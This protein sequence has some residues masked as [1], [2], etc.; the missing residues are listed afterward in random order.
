MNHFLKTLQTKRAATGHNRDTVQKNNNR[1]RTTHN[2]ATIPKG[3]RQ[4]SNDDI[5]K[6][7]VSLSRAKQLEIE[8]M[9][10]LEKRYE[11]EMEESERDKY[12]GYE[13]NYAN[14]LCD[15]QDG[16]GWIRDLTL[17]GVEPN[18]GWTAQEEEEFE[19][20]YER[21]ERE[22]ELDAGAQEYEDE[23]EQYLLDV[24]DRGGWERD[25]TE[26]G[27]EPNPGH[28][29]ENTG[30]METCNN[31]P[32]LVRDHVHKYTPLSGRQRRVAENAKKEDGEKKGKR[33]TPKYK[34]CRGDPNRCDRDHGH[35]EHQN[36]V[37]PLLAGLY[38]GD[39]WGHH[40]LGPQK[41]ETEF[42]VA[43][44]E[45]YLE[46]FKDLMPSRS[47]ESDNED[48]MPGLEEPEP[49][50]A[51]A[52]AEKEVAQ[53]ERDEEETICDDISTA[54]P[55][56][57]E[58][59]KVNND[60]EVKRLAAVAGERKRR[61]E[62]ER[63]H[64]EDR[65]A[66]EDD[67]KEVKRLAAVAGERKRRVECERRH[68]EDRRAREEGREVEEE[69]D[70]YTDDSDDE[71]EE[72]EKTTEGTVAVQEEDER[73][74]EELEEPV[75]DDVSTA[76]S[77]EEDSRT[78]E[79]KSTE[80]EEEDERPR[81]NIPRWP[82]VERDDEGS[83]EDVPVPPGWV[84]MEVGVE[85]KPELTAP[86]CVQVNNLGY[87]KGA[88]DVP[89][90]PL[91]SQ[92]HQG[93]PVDG[94]EHGHRHRCSRCNRIYYHVHIGRRKVTEYF[95]YNALHPASARCDVCNGK[96]KVRKNDHVTA[97]PQ[98]VPMP[99]LVP[100]FKQKLIFVAGE[101]GRNRGFLYN[102]LKAFSVKKK[103]ITRSYDGLHTTTWDGPV[104]KE[105]IEVLGLFTIGSTNEVIRDYLLKIG[106]NRQYMGTIATWM[107]ELGAT[108]PDLIAISM[109]TGKGGNVSAPGRIR[110]SFANND[111][112]KK[113]MIS[114]P[115]VYLDT[116]MA[117]CNLHLLYQLRLST[118][119]PRAPEVKLDF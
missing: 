9:M 30:G 35:Q 74:E 90:A 107:F 42:R 34:E 78:G 49:A 50:V 80:E 58:T 17:E 41:E 16:E 117:L 6:R 20:E 103:A 59:Q 100:G 62:C 65:R 32:C 84:K 7:G 52:P 3:M 46:A 60:K 77:T 55:Q 36:K 119:L 76:P 79:T 63:R 23:Y 104:E 98:L 115:E 111:K 108:K 113:L 64:G 5:R 26:E 37:C 48:E 13:N 110:G 66:R 89:L 10:R 38:S 61:V 29:H 24:M 40:L 43:E 82:N 19:E 71:E 116:I 99:T 14:Y 95:T 114:H 45:E 102:L 73:E 86:L 106:L 53:G 44:H 97:K 27:V 75:C 118:S 18:P 57:E 88:T 25:L 101:T 105:S 67:E 39:D 21:V 72:K 15:L 12:Y 8:S 112:V 33:S 85:K 109:V 22:M 47:E 96:D 54:P 93:M 83:V 2:E 92:T 56:G 94:D 31:K 51:S 68:E 91:Y 28:G 69:S 70:E 81:R 87:K 4:N 11:L 1:M